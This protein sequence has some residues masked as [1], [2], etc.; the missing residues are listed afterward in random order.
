MSFPDN[1]FANP[2]GEERALRV[3]EESFDGLEG[4]DG[5]GA[6][7]QDGMGQ[8]SNMFLSIRSIYMS[9]IVFSHYTLPVTYLNREEHRRVH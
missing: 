7:F 1:S 4:L 8:A 9:I 2:N 3:R 6:I 5:C